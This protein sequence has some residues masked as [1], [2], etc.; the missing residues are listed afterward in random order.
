M[1]A[2]AAYI[3]VTRIPAGATSSESVK[4]ANI[5]TNT[6]SFPLQGGLYGVYVVAT[7][8]GGSVTLQM[9][10]PDQATWFPALA[11][12]TANGYA[13]AQLPSGTYQVAVA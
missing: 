2:T 9:L 5:S 4:F 1:A 8:G 11:A 10:A 13:T 7:F 3:G 12:F 6:A